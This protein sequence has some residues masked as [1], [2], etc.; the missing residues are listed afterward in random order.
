MAKS[1]DAARCIFT[2]CTWRKF[3]PSPLAAKAKGKGAG[4][5]LIDALLD[6]SVRQS[7]TCVCLFTRIPEFFGQMGF[8]GCGQRT[9]PDKMHKDCLRC[10][11]MHACDETAMY[12]GELPEKTVLSTSPHAVQYYPQ[13]V[14][15]QS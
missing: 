13:L 11:R 3:A 8:Q 2:A 5:I 7:V 14:Q 6:E 1:W 9:L 15:L 4:R 10:P 12:M